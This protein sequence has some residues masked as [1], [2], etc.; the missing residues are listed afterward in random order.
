MSRKMKR[1]T[2]LSFVGKNGG[3]SQVYGNDNSD[4][5]KGSR[6]WE[7][8][9]DSCRTQSSVDSQVITLPR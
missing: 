5:S 9:F 4:G 8:V 3:N 1:I 7:N 6:Y 2:N